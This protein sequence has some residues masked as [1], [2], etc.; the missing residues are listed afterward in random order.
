MYIGERYACDIRII[1]SSSSLKQEHIVLE[2]T[3]H[4]DTGFANHHKV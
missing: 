3:W 4:E 2:G 1:F